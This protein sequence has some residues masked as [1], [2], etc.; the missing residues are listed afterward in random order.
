MKNRI[1]TLL[2]L[3]SWIFIVSLVLSGCGIGPQTSTP[4]SEPSATLPPTQTPT[5]VPPYIHY[6]P[7]VESNIQLEFDYPSNWSFSQNLDDRKFIILNFGDPRFRSLPTTYYTPSDFGTIDIWI[8]PVEPGQTSSTELE[9]TKQGYIGE[10]RHHVITDYMITIDGYDAGVLEYSIE[11]TEEDYPS[12]MFNKR[13][14]L[15]IN[16]QL[17]EILFRVAEKDRGG[18]FEKGFEYFLK[19]MKIVP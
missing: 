6:K 19:S 3:T 11:P 7:P 12:V 10:P 1:G 18:E 4:S 16:D 14:L 17:C 13:I 9:A 15:V 8:M 5:T 2:G